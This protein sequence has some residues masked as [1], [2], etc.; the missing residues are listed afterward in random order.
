MARRRWPDGDGATAMARWRD[1]IQR[2][3]VQGMRVQMALCLAVALTGC[4]RGERPEAEAQL[5]KVTPAAS[6]RPATPAAPAAP[7]A[8]QHKQPFVP[9]PAASA[10]P[11]GSAKRAK[12]DDLPVLPD[13]VAPEWK[14]ETR[15]QELQMQISER[16]GKPTRQQ[17][18]DT[19]GLSVPSLPGVTKSKLPNGD[20]GKCGTYAQM[21]Y[22]HHRDQLSAAQRR[23]ADRHFNP[24]GT[25]VVGCVMA[26]GTILH[27]QPCPV[28]KKTK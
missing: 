13:V 23:V 12:R 17:V 3:I 16:G 15:E 20:P 1:R 28:R 14:P 27:G 5:E 21:F 11:A 8:V 2:D 19:I 18:V 22:R 7:A 25:R 10:A 26:D 24:P 4:T 6:A 9:I